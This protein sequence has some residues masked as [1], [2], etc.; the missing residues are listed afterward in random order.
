MDI[1]RWVK[2]NYPKIPTIWGGWH[3][4]LFPKETLVQEFSVDITV[5]AQGEETFGELVTFFEHGGDL[6]NIKGIT[7]RK[8]GELIQNPGRILK[9]MNELPMVNYDLIPVETY[10]KLKGKRQLDYISSTGCNFRCTFCA[11]P[12]VFGRSWTGIE[13]ERLVAELKHWH[14]KY[15]FNDLNFQ[16]E[17]FFTHRKRTLGFA[18]CLIDSGL[19]ISW[20][21]TLRA[22][23]SSRIS[24]E[25]FSLIVRSGL[26]RVLI[27]VESGSQEMLDWLK[28]DIKLTQVYEAAERCKKHN[29]AVNFPFIV[30]FPGESD[31]S[32]K[33]SLKVAQYLHSLHPSFHTPVFY[34]KPYPGSAITQEVVN[35]GYKLPESIEEWSDFDFVGGVSG[36][37]VSEDIYQLVEKFKFYNK[38]AYRKHKWFTIPLQWTS[39]ARMKTWSFGFPFEKK[40]VEV[41]FKS[42][43]LS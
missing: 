16:D 9:N 19:K 11:D 18:Q 7:F 1:T 33:T 5:Q 4:S 10:Y 30:G 3:P 6:K 23:Q 42:Q 37:W 31:E 13:P 25:E 35:Q 15:P 22:D 21:G 2:Q 39:K 24:E 38:M 26:R 12:F 29:V 40:V 43:D 28:K 14:Q 41:M 36:P 34:F 32:V 17:T 27:G 8:E 20:A